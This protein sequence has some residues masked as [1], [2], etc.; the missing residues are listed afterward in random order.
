[1]TAPL[2]LVVVKRPEEA[3]RTSAHIESQWRDL[4]YVRPPDLERSCDQHSQLVSFLKTRDVTVLFLP[5]DERTG[6]DA[7]Y[8]HDPVLMTEQGAIILQT[9]KRARR[10]EGPAFA[11]ALTAWNVPILGA[12]EGAAYAEG[13]DLL[14]L[15]RNTLA[16]G[17]GFRTNAAGAEALKNLLHPLGVQLIEVEL[18]YWKGPQDVLHLMSLISLLDDDLAVVYRRLLPAP[19]YQFLCERRIQLIDVP[20]EEFDTMGCNVLALSPRDVLMLRGNPVTSERLQ[21]AGCIVAD[22][23]GSE[24]CLPGAGGPTC[25]TRPLWRQLQGER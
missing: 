16:V 3:F 1:M 23:D 9:G 25:L 12:L 8:A 13:G 11:E 5:A 4:N 10:G 14:W 7:L 6:L 18:P 21:S 19:F 17:R 20:E 24:I 15:D 2:R 22:F